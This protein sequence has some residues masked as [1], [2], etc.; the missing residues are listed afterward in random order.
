MGLLGRIRRG[1]PKIM[2]IVYKFRRVPQGFLDNISAIKELMGFTFCNN[3]QYLD[4]AWQQCDM[5]F[6]TKHELLPL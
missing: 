1:V 2:Q 5:K 4:L 6:N 3:I